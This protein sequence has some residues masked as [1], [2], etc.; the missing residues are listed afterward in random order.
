MM[1]EERF[2]HRLRQL[3]VSIFIIGTILLST[4][5]TTL[6]YVVRSTHETIHEQMKLEAQEYKN[7]I[8]KQFDKDFQ[9][10]HTLA[11]VIPL[12]HGELNNIG[13]WIKRANIQ[14]NDFVNIAFFNPE[15]KGVMDT[16][17]VG[18]NTNFLLASCNDDI[19]KAVK[20]SFLG[21]DTISHL[22]V[23]EFSKERLYVYSS[24]DLAERKSNWGF[25]CQHSSEY[26]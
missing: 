11:S 14:D 7:R 4:G 6:L 9:I 5:I 24:S 10:L 13:E 19:Q 18:L 1:D 17:G 26:F 12:T 2:R 25:G 16:F 15:G 23:S 21:K 20:Q 3:S 22:F 8:F